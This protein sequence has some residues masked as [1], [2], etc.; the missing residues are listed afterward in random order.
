MDL[1]STA[2]R[3]GTNGA[4]IWHRVHV[5]LASILHPLGIVINCRLFAFIL[6]GVDL[7]SPG[8]YLSSIQHRPSIDIGL[9]SMYYQFGINLVLI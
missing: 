7:A 8:V 3:F 5:D 1:G 9:V 6:D 2:H 4:S